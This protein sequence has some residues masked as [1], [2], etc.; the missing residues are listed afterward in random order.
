MRTDPAV[1]ASWSPGAD[2]ADSTP[3]ERRPKKSRTP[4]T[5]RTRA[6]NPFPLVNRCGGRLPV[7]VQPR[8]GCQSSKFRTISD[9]PE[10]ITELGADL[11]GSRRPA[12]HC[13]ESHAAGTG[14]SSRSAVE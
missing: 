14:T 5:A 7:P 9:D 2:A 8:D 3:P 13:F 10:C 4:K 6:Q 11:L 12:D 1:G